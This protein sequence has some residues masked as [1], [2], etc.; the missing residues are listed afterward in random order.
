MLDHYSLCTDRQTLSTARFCRTTQL[1][2]ADTWFRTC[3][4]SSFCTVAWQLARFQLTWRIA[5]SLGDSWASASCWSHAAD[6]VQQSTVCDES[7]PWSRH[8][9]WV[10]PRRFSRHHPRQ[11]HVLS[12]CMVWSLL[13]I[14]PCNTGLISELMQAAWFLSQ[15]LAVPTISDIFSNVDDLFKNSHHVL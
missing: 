1:A 5:P 13:S 4:T 14:T 2:T 12:P 7:P 11:D 10:A 9:D 8:L 6:V 15:I 3:R